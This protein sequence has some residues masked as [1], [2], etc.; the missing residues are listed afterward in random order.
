MGAGW[1]SERFHSRRETSTFNQ[2]LFIFLTGKTVKRS[3][4]EVLLECWGGVWGIGFRGTGEGKMYKQLLYS[5]SR[6]GLWV[7]REYLLEFGF[8]IKQQSKGGGW[9]WKV[10]GIH[11]RCGQGRKEGCSRCA[12]KN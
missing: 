11:R 7:S 4:P 6:S 12:L 5:P 8:L 10:C 3:H 1:D 9:I 2:D